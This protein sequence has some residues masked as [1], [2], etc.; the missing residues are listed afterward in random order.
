MEIETK[1]IEGNADNPMDSKPFALRLGVAIFC[2]LIAVAVAIGY[3]LDLPITLMD[4]AHI[5]ERLRELIEMT[6]NSGSFG[7]IVV[8]ALYASGV[9]VAAPSALMTYAV[10]LVFGLWAIPISFFGAVIGLMVAFTLAR[11]ALSKQISWYCQ[12]FPMLRGI[13]TALDKNGFWIIFLLRQSP[14]IPFSAQ[15][16]MFGV[17]RIPASTYFVASALG[18]IPGTLAKVYIFEMANKAALDP[19]MSTTNYVFGAIGIIATIF[20]MWLVGKSVGNELKAV[21]AID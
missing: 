16:Y 3:A 4:G 20:V 9:V 18:I 8:I 2:L 19:S 14:I 10:T 21:N 13:E 15:N 7:V 12:R 17:L 11:V 5:V 1:K 6:R